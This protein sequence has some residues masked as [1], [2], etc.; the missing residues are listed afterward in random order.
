MISSAVPCG[1]DARRRGSRRRAPCRCTKSAARI[2]SSS[3]STTTRCCPVAQAL[4]AVEQAVVVARVQADRGLVEDVEHAHQA[5][6]HLGREPDALPLAA[7]ERGAGAVEGEVAE[8]DF[9]QEAQPLADLAQ[10]AVGDDALRGRRARARRRSPPPASTESARQVGDREAPPI[11]HAARLGAQPRA[12]AGGAGPG[13]PVAGQ[14]LALELA[15]AL[16]AALELA[17]HAVPAPR[18]ALV[19]PAACDLEA[20][21]PRPRAERMPLLRTLRGSSLPRRVEVDLVV[22]RRAPRAAGR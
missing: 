8:A 4:E 11:A 9:E 19:A 1:D 21:S 16:E 6:A 7:R 13:A 20:R 10:D 17:E 22:L 18:E 5:R 14:L 3:C 12:L 15:A 2:V